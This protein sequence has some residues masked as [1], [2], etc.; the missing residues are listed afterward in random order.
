MDFLELAKERYSVRM[1]SNQPIEKEKINRILEAGRVAP[2][3]HNNQPQR[4]YVIQSEEAREK[5]K[6]CT[7][8]SF[9]APCILL[10][11]YNEDE[12]WYGP[13]NKLG[14]IDASIVTTHMIMEA[15]ELGLG[16]VWV[17]S[18]N[19]EIAKSEFAL[20]KNI[21][22]VAFLPVGYPAEM[23]KPSPMHANRKDMSETVSYL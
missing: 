15:T 10:I 8:Y 1:Y 11:C 13:D 17:G 3:A 4:I 12:S 6:K 7:R 23:A 19:A 5:V 14:S 16:T 2:T 21:I 9:S 18:F 20:P 22:P